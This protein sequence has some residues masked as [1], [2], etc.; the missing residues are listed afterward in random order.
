MTRQAAVRF[1]LAVSIVIGSYAASAQSTAGAA[2][3]WE[4]TVQTPGQPLAISVDLSP[5]PAGSWQGTITIPAQNVTGFALSAISVEG[6]RVT[7]SMKGVP[8]EP[9]F[10]GTLSKEPRSIS[11]ELSQGGATIP[12]TLAWKGEPNI[13]EPAK[14]SAITKDFEGSWEGALTVQGTILRLVAKLA[15]QAGSG[16][17]TIVSLDQGGVEIPVTTISQEGS[18]LHLIIGAIRASYDGDLKDGQIDGTWAQ[19]GQRF[20]LVFKRA[21]K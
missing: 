14:S 6:D 16:V 10:K 19:G 3:H 11:G 15:N 12:F 21:P 5:Q 2:G 1:V 9:L 17:G 18:H 13:E 8:G 4:G 7:F 20:P